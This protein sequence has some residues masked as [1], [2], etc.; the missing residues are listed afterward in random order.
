MR[1]PAST[2]LVLTAALLVLLSGAVPVQAGW[3]EFRD[4]LLRAKPDDAINSPYGQAVQ[5]HFAEFLAKAADETCVAEKKLASVAFSDLAHTLL[6]SALQHFETSTRDAIDAERA[7]ATF[8]RDAGPLAVNELRGLA[9]SDVVGAATSALHLQH[10]AESIKAASAFLSMYLVEQK[11]KHFPRNGV[12]SAQLFDLYQLATD[13]PELD[14]NRA[15]AQLKRFF[16]LSDSAALALKSSADT[17]KFMSQLTDR[18]RLK[19]TL[20]TP[21]RSHCIATDS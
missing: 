9:R 17:G 18:E 10:G 5:A 20:G 19:S 21:L 8:I 11:V 1:H 16:E 12:A 7:N 15:S 2:C 13:P 4:L 14:L 6:T 3:P